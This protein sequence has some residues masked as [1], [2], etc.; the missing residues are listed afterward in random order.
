LA[1][2]SAQGEEIPESIHIDFPAH[3][4]GKIKSSRFFGV[5]EMRQKQI[6][7]WMKLKITY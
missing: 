5:V 3:N 1:F 6:F 4:R 7:K 2:L